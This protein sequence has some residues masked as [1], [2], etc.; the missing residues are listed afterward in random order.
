MKVL[1]LGGAGYVGS[2][3]VREM[4]NHGHEVTCFDLMMFGA[5]SMMP[6]LGRPDFTL[7]KGDIRN[8]ED[9]TPSAST[10]KPRSRPNSSPSPPPATR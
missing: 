7:V 6:W 4:L 10:A 5:E 9:S 8:A 2:A 3:V 1:V